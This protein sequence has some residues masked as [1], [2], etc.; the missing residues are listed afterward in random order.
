MSAHVSRRKFMLVQREPFLHAWDAA[1]PVHDAMTGRIRHYRLDAFGFACDRA[2][3]EAAKQPTSAA[4]ARTRR[5]LEDDVSLDRAWREINDPSNRP[6]PAVVLE[7]IW[8][9]VCERGP[10]ALHEPKNVERLNRCDANARAEL[11]RRLARL[12]ANK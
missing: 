4:V 5:L 7:A 11:E 12:R 6:T 8:W 1:F 9:C 10:Q 2:E 3:L